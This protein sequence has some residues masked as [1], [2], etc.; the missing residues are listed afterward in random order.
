MFLVRRL[1]CHKEQA[2]KMW[3]STESF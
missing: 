1:L 2:V 3:I